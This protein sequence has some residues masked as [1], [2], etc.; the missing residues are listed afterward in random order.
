MSSTVPVGMRTPDRDR[1]ASAAPWVR[2]A[3]W[4]RCIQRCSFGERGPEQTAAAAAC[5]RYSKGFMCFVL[6]RRRGKLHRRPSHTPLGRLWVKFPYSS[7]LSRLQRPSWTTGL[8]CLYC[9]LPSY[10]L[11][12]LNDCMREEDWPEPELGIL[13][14]PRL[15]ALLWLNPLR[16]DERRR[17]CF[18]EA[19]LCRHLRFCCSMGMKQAR[20]FTLFDIAG[21]NP[22]RGPPLKP[23]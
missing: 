3:V 15:C 8:I 16:G 4:N 11:I 22:R 13:S 7:S 6:N 19:L 12:W 14:T 18:P 1:G 5:G 21:R 9:T 2:F 20:L 23:F 17:V 10:D